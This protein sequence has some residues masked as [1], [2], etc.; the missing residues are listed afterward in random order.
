M[1]EQC[2]ENK[3]TA[4]DEDVLVFYLEK[5][6]INSAVDAI[7]RYPLNLYAP[8]LSINQWINLERGYIYF[9]NYQ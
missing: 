1:T 6:M 2:Q 7:Q 5:E 3:L 9:S 4:Y 8:A